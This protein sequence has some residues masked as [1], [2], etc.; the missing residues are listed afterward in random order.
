[1]YSLQY[2][3]REVNLKSCWYILVHFIIYSHNLDVTFTVLFLLPLC[4][5]HYVRF[6][7]PPVEIRLL[8][9]TYLD[10]LLIPDI[11]TYETT[12]LITDFPGFNLTVNSR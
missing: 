6:V 12:M 4:S 7:L 8:S 1:M 11:T 5:L 2:A 9:Q 10:L 3:N